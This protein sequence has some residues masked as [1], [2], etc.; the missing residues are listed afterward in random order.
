MRVQAYPHFLFVAFEVLQLDLRRM[1][2]SA[3][4]EDFCCACD[5]ERCG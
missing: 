3:C 1:Q 5:R 4:N 2:H